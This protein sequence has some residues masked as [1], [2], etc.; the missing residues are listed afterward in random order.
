MRYA[1]KRGKLLVKINNS[2]VKSRND[3]YAK[4]RAIMR[5]DWNNLDSGEWYSKTNALIYF[6]GYKPRKAI[7]ARFKK[8]KLVKA[9]PLK[10]L[11]S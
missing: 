10:S 7:L 1:Q 9:A 8:V 2:M 11:F 6:K 3:Y 5:R 4:K